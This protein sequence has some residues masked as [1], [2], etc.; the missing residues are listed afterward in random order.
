MAKFAYVAVGKDGNKV[1]GIINAD[2]LQSAR[3]LV[4]EKGLKPERITEASSDKNAAEGLD[5]SLGIPFLGKPRGVHVELT[6]R[7]IAV[8]I[9]S[10]MTLLSAI[11][12]VIDQ[13][14]SRAVKRMYQQVRDSIEG[15]K[16]L[17]ASLDDHPVF[18]R[19]IIAMINLGEESG[20][21]ET[22]L[23]RCAVAMGSQRRNRNAMLTAMAYPAFTFLFAIA[24]SVYIVVAVIPPMKRAMETL[25]RKLPAMTQSLLDVSDF[26]VTYGPTIGIAVFSVLTAIVF[27]FLWPPGRLAIDKFS[28]K[29]PLFGHVLKTGGTAT[30]SRSLLILLASGIP[31]VEALRILGT[32]HNNRYF[33]AVVESARNRILEG[34]T[35]GSSLDRG[36]AYTPMMIRMIGVGET[37]GNLEEIL[38][39]VADFHDERLQALIKQ[40]SALLEPA[41]VLVVGGIVGYVYIAFFIGLYGAV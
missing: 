34:A 26:V 2:T 35:L 40:L 21:L 27:V 14:P 19:G 6:L 10:G 39:N 24:V 31:L 20:N 12:T 33:V 9:K 30:F 22:V 36:K 41:I 7:Q 38:S 25:G 17:A 3:W 5:L 8:M 15:G 18:H 29:V 37:S 4:F 1:E 28:L 16:S 11:E 32:I 23:E 13:P